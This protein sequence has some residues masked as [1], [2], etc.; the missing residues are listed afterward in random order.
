MSCKSYYYVLVGLI[1]LAVVMTLALYNYILR[2][3]LGQ[4][5][6]FKEA[7]PGSKIRHPPSP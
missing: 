6:L 1:V 7:Q 2:R 4:E 3:I 5:L